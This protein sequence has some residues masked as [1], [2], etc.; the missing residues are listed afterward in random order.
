V[1]QHLRS[2]IMLALRPCRFLFW[3]LGWL[4]LFISGM[5]SPAH[6]L[7]QG[8][9]PKVLKTFKVFGSAETTG[10]TMMS[11]SPPGNV[12]D[13]LLPSN[14]A[15]IGG[16]PFDGKLV[17]AYL[18]WTG[19]TD[20]TADFNVDYTL[21]NGKKFNVR[22]D[23]CLT[24]PALGGF[25]YCRKEVTSLI[26]TN[27]QGILNG[28]YTV[29]GLKAK[30]GNCQQ[31]PSICQ[32]RYAAWSMVLVWESS[33]APIRRDIVLYDGFLHMDEQQSPPTSGVT[34]FQLSGFKVGNPPEGKFTYFGLEGDQFLGSPPEPSTNADFMSLRFSS[35]T[36]GTRLTSSTPYNPSGN[37][38]NST[39]A[40][41]VDIDTF[42][43]GKSGLN[44]IKPGDSSVTVV[45]GTGDGI[46]PS[47]NGES[48]LLGYVLMTVDTLTPNFRNTKTVKRVDKLTA[49]VGDTLTYTIRVTNSGSL[50]GKN[51]I[52]TD[53]I[54]ANTTYIA[55]S[56]RVGGKLVADV[57]GTSP[58]VAGLNLGTIDF[59]GNN[60]REITFQ[61]RIT[62]TPANSRIENFFTVKSDEVGS[63][64]SNTVVTTLKIPQLGSFTKTVRNQTNPGKPI[65]PGD[66]IVYTVTG[67]V[68]GG[69]SI[70]GAQFVD[71]LPKYV[72][73]VSVFQ[74]PGSQNRSTSTGGANGTGR[75]DIRN[76]SIPSSGVSV[77]ITVRVFTEAEFKA[78]GINADKID[79]TSIS[80]QGEA[81]LAGVS[82]TV[83]TDD[84][85]TPAQQDP[86]VFQVSYKSNFSTS[87]KTV[88]DGNGG[89]PEPGD[90]LTYTV[91]FTNSGTRNATATWEDNLPPGVTNYK[92]GTSP[93]GSKVTFQAAPAGANRTGLLTV[94]GINLPVGGTARL[95]FTVQIANNATNGQPVT[96]IGDIVDEATKAR[97][98]IS[99]STLLVVSGPILN[100]STKA[101]VN[102]NG[103]AV[104]APG[105][106]VR[107]TIVVKNTG[108]KPATNVVVKDVVSADLEQIA[109]TPTSALSGNTITWNS[110]NTSSLG[111]IAAGSS[112]TLSFTAKVK[113]AVADGKLISNQAEITTTGF[114]R[115]V[116]TD[117]PAT[118]R[119]P[120]ATVFRVSAKAELLVQ[121]IVTDLNGGSAAPGD[122]IR[123]TITIRNNGT[124]PA[125]DVVVTD[126][127]S[128]SLTGAVAGQGGVLA[129]N[130]ITWNKTSTPGLA[131]IAPRTAVT[132]TVEASIKTPLANNTVIS[133]QATVKVSGKPDQKSDDPNTAAPNDPTNLTV[134][135]TATP[136]FTKA[137][138]DLNGGKFV[139]GD[140]VEYTLTIRGGGNA[141]LQNVSITDTVDNNLLNIRATQGTVTGRIIRWDRSTLPALATINPGQSVTLTFTAQIVGTVANKTKI[142]NQG[143][144]AATG[145]TAVRSDDPKTPAANDATV[146]E[147]S[148]EPDLT[149]TT[150]T[151]VDA[152]GGQILPGDVLSYTIT[153]RNTGNVAATNVVITDVID[154]NLVNIRPN[155][156]GVFNAATRTIT[157]NRTTL[158]GLASLRPGLVGI[159]TFT[160]QVKSPIADKTKISN[161]ATISGSNVTATR[162]DDPN[163]AADDDPTVVE[164]TSGPSF[165]DTTKEVRDVN[166]GRF[167]PRDVVEYTIIVKNSGTDVARNVVVTDPVDTASLEAIQ[168]GQGGV[169]AN[170]T[171]TWTAQSFSALSQIPVGGSV[172]LTF[173]ARIKAAVL[174]GT[175]IKNQAQ[176][177]STKIT[178][179]V[180]SDDPRT[181]DDDDETKFT[182]VAGSDL[183]K[184]T[185]TFV[186]NNGGQ[187]QPGDII[188]YTITL[189]NNGTG[190]ARNVVVTDKIDTTRLVNI[191]PGQG[192]VFANGTITWQGIPQLSSIAQGVTTRVSFTARI[193]PGLFRGT[194]I[195]NQAF[196]KAADM[197][198]AAPTDDPAT[199]AL[200]DP[201]VLTVG[202]QPN[203][204]FTKEVTDISGAPTRPGDRIRYTITVR[205]SGN[206][207]ATSVVI[208]DVIDAN[209]DNVRVLNNGT[210]N[211]GTRQAVWTLGVI[212]INGFVRFVVEADVKTGTANGTVI[213]N[214]ALLTSTE[215]TQ[216][217]RSDDPNKPGSTDSTDITVTSTTRV[218]FT[219]RARAQSGNVFRPGSTFTYILTVQ[220]QGQSTLT[221]LTVRDTVNTIVSI[222]TTGG[223]TQ[224]GNTLEWNPTNTSSLRS[225][226][227]NGSI[228]L[229]FTVRISPNAADGTTF[230]NQGILTNTAGLNVLSDDPGTPAANDPTVVT[231]SSPNLSGLTKEVRDTNGGTLE[232]GDEVE[233][234]ITVRSTSKTAVN[235]VV[236]TDAV[237]TTNLENIRVGQQGRFAN[238]TITWDKTSLPALAKV[239]DQSTLRLTFTARVKS[240]VTSGT[241]VSNQAFAR[242]DEVTTPEPS[243][244]PTTPAAKDPTRVTVRQAPNLSQTTKAVTDLNGGVARPGDRV[245]YT[246]TVRNSGSQTATSVVVTDR[247]N[248][249]L[250]NIQVESG[251]GTFANGTITWN[252]ASIPSGSN[253]ELRFTAV[254]ANTLK[255]GDIVPNQAFVR[256]AE[257]TTAVPSD[258]PRTARVDDVTNVVIST[259]P[260]LTTSTKTV[261]DVNGGSV[262]PGDVL[263]YTIR[264]VNGGSVSAQ[265]V[266]LVDPTPGNTDYVANSLRLNGVVITGATNPLQTGLLVQSARAGT[267]PGTVVPDDGA[268][269]DDEVAVVTFQVRVRTGTP[270]GTRIR[271]QGVL[272]AIGVAPTPTDNPATPAVGDPTDVIVGGGADLANTTKTVTIAVDKATP[273]QADV[274]DVLEYTITIQN[275]GADAATSLVFRDPIPANSRF[276][277]GS[278]RVNGVAKT[279]AGGDDE[280]EY[281]SANKW[282]IV[283]AASLAANQ[284]LTVTFRVEIEGGTQIRNQG[285]VQAANFRSEPTDAD[286][287]DANGNQPTVIPV[288]DRALLTASKQVSD[289]NGGSVIA[290]D[291][292]LYTITLQNNGSK[293]ITGI[294]IADVIPAKTTYQANSAQGPGTNKY[295]AG[296]RTLTFENIALQPAGDPG[297]KVTVTFL[298]RINNS[299]QSGDTITNKARVTAS[300][301][302]PTDTNEAKIKLGEGVGDGVLSG[303][304]FQDYGS[305]DNRYDAKEDEALAGFK[306]KLFRKGE[307]DKDPI[308]ET[309]SKDDGTYSLSELPR[310]EFVLR[311]YSQKDVLFGELEVNLSRGGRATRDIVV[312]P[313]G[314]VYNGETGALVSDAKVY[315]LYDDGA[316]TSCR[317]DSDCTSKQ[318]CARNKA[319]DKEGRCLEKVEDKFLLA[320]QQ[321]QA[322][323]A[324]GMYLFSVKSSERTLRLVVRPTD[325]TLAFPSTKRPAGA[326]VVDYDEFNDNGKVV[327]QDRPD[328]TDKRKDTTY[329]LR[330]KVKK[331]GDWIQ[332]NHLALDS[333]QSLLVLTK[334]ASIQVATIG[335]IVTYTV[336]LENNSG[337]ALTRDTVKNT[338]GV[339][340]TDILPKGFRLLKNS[341]RVTRSDG[342]V[343]LAGVRGTKTDGKSR[344]PQRIFRFG[345]FD[346]PARSTLTLRYQTVVGRNL[347]VGRYINVAFAHNDAG[348]ELTTRARSLVR[349]TFD[350]IFDQGTVIGKVFCDKNGNRWQ[351]I[352][353][354]GIEK[355]RLYLDNG[356]YVETDRYGKFRIQAIDPGNHML[357]LDKQTLPPG[358]KMLDTVDRIFY[359]SRGLLR[360]INFAVKCR[361]VR[362]GIQKVTL[363]KKGKRNVANLRRKLYPEI[364]L[365]G[366]VYGPKLSI[367]GKAQ[368][369][370]LVSLGLSYGSSL[371]SY[372]AGVTPDFK[373]RNGRLAK[374]IYFNVRTTATQ[375]TAFW[376]LD[377]YAA[378]AKGR[379]G[380]RL[381]TLR[382][383]GA[384]PPV[385]R[386]NGKTAGG[387]RIVRSGRLYFARLQITLR[388][389][390]ITASPPRL[391]GTNWSIN[392]RKV[393][394]KKIF[395]TRSMGRNGSRVRG[396]LARAFRRMSMNVRLM[397]MTPGAQVEVEV[398]HHNRLSREAALFL[399]INR[400][401]S[402]KRYLQKLFKVPDSRIRARGFGSDKP[403]M[404]NNSR[405]GRRRNA[406]IVF[407]VVQKVQVKRK[408]PKVRFR[409][410]VLLGSKSIKVTSLGSFSTVLKKPLPKKIR[411]QIITPF[412]AAISVLLRPAQL[413]QTSDAR[414]SKKTRLPRGYW[415]RRY[416]RWLKKQE[417]LARKKRSKVKLPTTVPDLHPSLLMNKDNSLLLKFGDA[418]KLLS[419]VDKRDVPVFSLKLAASRA[420]SMLAADPSLAA[421]LRGL[422]RR[423]KRL[424]RRL[425]V[426]MSDV[427]YKPAARKAARK[428]TRRTARR[429]KGGN[430][431]LT[432]V[433]VNPVMMVPAAKLSVRLPP[434]G[435][436]IRTETFIVK[437]Y[438][439]PKNRLVI[440]GKRVK[441]ARNGDFRIALKLKHGQK[442]LV[443]TT[444]DPEGNSGRVVWPIYV[445]LNRLFLL[446]M[447]EM[448]V[449]QADTPMDGLDGLA[450]FKGGGVLVH[451][452]AVLYAKGR[453]QG[454]HILSKLFKKIRYTAYFETPKQ[455]ELEAFYQ[456]L[457]DPDK[458]YP[459]YGDSS[460]Q[461][462]DVKARGWRFTVGDTAYRMP[463]YVML[464]A[465]RSKLVVGNFRTKL[466]GIELNRYDRTFHGFMVDFQKRFAKRFDTRV[467]VFVSD[468]D[469]QQQRGHIQMR[470]TGGSLYYLKHR[471]ILEGSEQIRVTVRDRD[472]GIILAKIPLTRDEHYSIQYLDGRLFFKYPI[473]QVVDSFL[474][475]Q[476]NLQTTLNGH[477]V[478]IEADYEYEGLESNGDVSVGVRLRQTI[479]K[480][481]R[482]GFTFVR[483]G[484]GNTGETAYMLWGFDLK[485]NLDKSTHMVAEFSRSESYDTRAFT[486]DDGGLTFRRM[487]RINEDETLSQLSGNAFLVRGVSEVSRYFKWKDKVKLSVGAYFAYRDRGFFA[488]FQNPEQGSVKGGT[489]IRAVLFKQHKLQ[490]KYDGLDTTRFDVL[491][492]RLYQ[493]NKQMFNL[494]YSYDITKQWN[495]VVEYAHTADYDERD[496]LTLHGNFVTLG[497]NWK[498]NRN[499]D[500]I[501][502]QQLPVGSVETR[503]LLPNWAD[504]QDGNLSGQ[505]DQFATTLGFNLRVFKETF[506]SASGILRWSGNHSIQ[507]GLKTKL[508]ENTTTY[509]RERLTFAQQSTGL[510]HTLVIGAER[511]ASKNSRIYGEYQMDGA[512]TGNNTRAVIGLNHIVQLSK[513]VLLG[514]GLERAQF[515]DPTLGLSSRTVG[516]I[517]F[518]LVRFKNLKLS[519]RV[520]VRYDGVDPRFNQAGSDRIQ[521]VTFNNVVW[522]INSFLSFLGRV[523]YAQT[524]NFG[525]NKGQGGLE[526]ELLQGTVGLAFRPERFDWF[527]MLAKY[528]IRIEQRPL[529]LQG[530]E[531]QRAMTEV[532]S[533]TPIFELPFRLQIL[534]QVAIKY[535]EEQVP[536]LQTASSAVMLWINR[537][538]FHL[539]KKIDLGVEYRLMWMWQ[540]SAGQALEMSTFDHGVL[541]EA[542]YNVHR[543]F[544]VGVGYNFTRFT[545]NLLLDGN[546]DYSGFFVRAVGKY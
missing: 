133:N 119:T 219:K 520:E 465:D 417:R 529:S 62:G 472:S 395:L 338:G 455:R 209:L 247:I 355:V 262:E 177:R 316:A 14:S 435:S 157:W 541:V 242:G 470:G 171:I 314:R 264:V 356:H 79:G 246:I 523:N 232:P 159:V 130:T 375:G 257:I 34:S 491:T 357:K 214:Q 155:Q 124:A 460:R 363:S 390:S 239:S 118:T 411:I 401:N 168:P 322:T 148:S 66:T 123:Y 445:N 164:V 85:G 141:P 11:A 436:V 422:P 225:I 537:L 143:V 382:G 369:L 20:G 405:R 450:K 409:P 381:R 490:L 51:V 457:I 418:T 170:N 7:V 4:L 546:R 305:D 240:T 1:F 393:L 111:S 497:A 234:T 286:G 283:R 195:S 235:N 313:T 174:N 216:P 464:E 339:F 359:V 442:K 510:V 162:S 431:L 273:G 360:K 456:R 415:W 317:L 217:L 237:D 265:Q 425:R 540:G 329:Y 13:I 91:E 212:N 449:G 280:G 187:P 410:R 131:A 475:T 82:T 261:R 471:S 511:A 231:I 432:Q 452:R 100:T 361:S 32:A 72:K 36:S 38:W 48:V 58:L 477:P 197:Q 496:G 29:G 325:P 218:V 493:Y 205:N 319:N 112:V 500:F 103:T 90:T 389:Q 81:R 351:D 298:V 196:A 368:A 527:N 125:T 495:V 337:L 341:P 150:K 127:L 424:K 278:I 459:I 41:G 275:T 42:N 106:T 413:L 468:G 19:S 335:D 25:F 534:E 414:P 267:T 77:F 194:R 290:G 489:L 287:N 184:S 509:I 346:L 429:V 102:T 259:L 88:A 439:H 50:A 304:I 67:R 121:K 61:V 270:K 17:S 21:P 274:G 39:I 145:I 44:L 505:L 249:A 23:S 193:A 57:G 440:N 222:Q 303:V 519:S 458:Y 347:P 156:G 116:L 306:I 206:A 134:R 453:I 379:R 241:V 454:K 474:L 22:A 281:D 140:T 153:V 463:V 190:V 208:T 163:T 307:T 43:I 312:R 506:V 334:A 211:S 483:E 352:G 230:P 504:G 508:N 461:V 2:I 469:A 54:P 517:S 332:N 522:K 161:Q 152:N 73:F 343:L 364:K 192:G 147:V 448:T 530:G 366:S 320:G 263:E 146:F 434:K 388:D 154:T 302:S 380:R 108:N 35:S 428:K 172:T 321:G 353:D 293:A 542:A 63:S 30:P 110:S 538:N 407:R 336:K 402:V 416:R 122:K 394:M 277:S 223:A 518:Q 528:T 419:T 545:D 3:T 76:I 126:P 370:P 8:Q 376:R 97:T 199:A 276:V 383:V 386:W 221:N 406:R 308:K 446:A 282:M 443:I 524:W 309:V 165:A 31:N 158:P 526:G 310:T 512:S 515:L 120:D 503:Q 6:A 96:N 98:R 349:V 295:D 535:R 516:R 374:P 27:A 487:R 200:D 135:S 74:P 279:D 451:G 26:K 437:G 189:S 178:N 488:S 315:L 385:I 15:S 384:P 466:N 244:D 83:K 254:L 45:A 49:S 151:V 476:Y 285:V 16:V 327:P 10:N 399:T 342:K 397:L 501:L 467:K 492:S 75:I 114:P 301:I 60:E 101:V 400:A 531:T 144:L 299:A 37:I 324:Q 377:I 202:G 47:G 482:V 391:F 201:T 430:T 203:L 328:I 210:F 340:I 186:D 207:P 268:A 86:T 248:V 255:N 354:K 284:T 238:G 433:K 142:S 478:F 344:N 292:L 28:T 345:P 272:S 289:V 181:V 291:N 373:L 71:D 420:K 533:I 109:V 9:A 371:P 480:H 251:G 404:P 486:S 180:S 396:R 40:L 392:E 104:Y 258:D 65:R 176:V 494:Q 117:D 521:V 266:R 513:G 128:S 59:R 233:Y 69:S 479:T 421:K 89:Q 296:S 33:T 129:S 326:K 52:V 367:E 532:F 183:S 260:S 137:V 220:N 227:P 105:D 297:D 80:N 215:I 412:G 139:P 484:K 408:Y 539:F 294:K 253:V 24:V 84:P 55:N 204:R 250:T 481:A 387:G 543:Y 213:K 115:P 372:S 56:T 426:A 271:N 243:D 94:T 323:N 358:S 185:K 444:R 107:Y 514:G 348:G 378:S 362:V 330:F 498:L 331:D 438:T 99:S 423:T 236:V 93:A 256:S 525:L 179:A 447:G 441:V 160:A 18:W 427:K 485:L 269:P 169:F 182:V 78:A 544:Y 365:K 132:L 70:S 499:I 311:Y 536:G 68:Q 5:S 113:A 87:K 228:N 136:T 333:W 167:V 64:R 149:S 288:G 226:P 191:Q 507:A 473:P 46:V 92:I 95:T 252:I 398:H 198:T 350:P 462:Q 245:R 166:G 12:N 318:L 300:E 175:E 173:R 229:T 502:R 403:R 224:T 138:R 53:S 188:T